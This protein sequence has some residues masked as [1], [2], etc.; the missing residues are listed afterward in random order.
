MERA[1]GPQAGNDGGATADRILDAALAEFEQSGL[2]STPLEAIALRAGVGRVTLYRR[3]GGREALIEAVVLR[4]MQ[5]F[6][7]ELEAVVSRPG[8]IAERLVEGLVLGVRLARSHPLYNRVIESEPE[9][10][11]PYVTLEGEPLVAAASELVVAQLRDAVEP[12][13]VAAARIPHV[14]ETAVRVA[15]SLVLTPRAADGEAE[16][17]TFASAVIAPLLEAP[18][19]RR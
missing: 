19:P 10:I 11:L 17:R 14:A 5:R 3:F 15:Q 6:L 12:D 7:G 1:F 16:L 9:T 4:E 18:P 2:R 8:P 13:S